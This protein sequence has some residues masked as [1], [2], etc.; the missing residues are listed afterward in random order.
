MV[1]EIREKT[2]KIPA[3]NLSLAAS[4]QLR[5]VAALLGRLFSKKLINP[6]ASLSFWVLSKKRKEATLA[7]F[8]TNIL[9]VRLTDAHFVNGLSYSTFGYFHRRHLAASVCSTSVKIRNF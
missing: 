1:N 4:D 9:P 2:R 7:L 8:S 3:I 6:N 5:S